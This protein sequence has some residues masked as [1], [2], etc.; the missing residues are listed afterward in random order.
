MACVT[1]SLWST[2]ED[3]AGDLR[4]HHATRVLLADDQEEIRLTLVSILESEFEV[5]GT[6]ENGQRVLELL[7]TKSPD[8]LVL[9]IFMPVLN[10]IEVASYLKASGCHTKV[11]FVTVQDDPDF[12]ETAISLGALGYVLKAHVATDLIPAMRSVMED[13]VYISP[14][15]HSV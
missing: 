13:R 8:V 2:S 4:G 9:D 11:L 7:L 3:E 14:S 5:V 10:G 15:M 1:S 6:A 12:L